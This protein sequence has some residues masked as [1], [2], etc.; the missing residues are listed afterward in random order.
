MSARANGDDEPLMQLAEAAS[1]DMAE[2][3]QPAEQEAA[4]VGHN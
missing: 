4:E 2:S 1:E 3:V